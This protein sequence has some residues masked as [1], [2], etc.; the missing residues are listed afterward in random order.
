MGFGFGW[1]VVRA[2]EGM[3]AMLSPG[4]FGHGGAFGTQGWIDPKKD[5]LTIL[6]IGRTGLPNG[7]ASDVRRELQ[8]AAYDA[9]VP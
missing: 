5:L 6:M 9:L 8:Q 3:T 7:D 1:T 4:T 2:P